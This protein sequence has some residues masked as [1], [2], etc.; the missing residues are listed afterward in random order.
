[1]KNRITAVYITD[2]N[3][4]MPTYISIF[5]MIK[6]K[7][8][9]DLLK[10]YLIGKGLSNQTK[11]RYNTLLCKDV[12]LE[13]IEV[14][15]DKYFLLSKTCLF[16]QTI[17]VSDAALFKM[18][19]PDLL[20]DEE[21]IL[22]IDGD[23]LIQGSLKGLFE[24]NIEKEYVAAV[25]DQ[26]D[27]KINGNSSFCHRIGLERKHYFNSGVMLLNLKKMRADNISRRLL[28][29]R[30][31]GINYFMDQD[32]LNA[33]LGERLVLLPCIYN[34]MSTISDVYDAEEIGEKFLGER[35]ESIEDCISKSI[36]LHLTDK[37]KP[38]IYNIPWYSDIF[39]KYYRESVYGNEKIIFKSPLKVLRD[40][41]QLLRERMNYMIQHTE[42]VF[43]YQL[44][45]KGS[46]V[47]LYGAG[48]MGQ[49]FYEQIQAT[50]YCNIVAWIDKRGNS[51]M[52]Q[53]GFPED[54]VKVTYDF[55]LIAI[56][57]QQIVS[58][59]KNLLKN[60]YHVQTEKI[61]SKF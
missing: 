59:V 44:L 40:E 49:S 11:S 12:S 38:W 37:K 29:Y 17:H 9:E 54:I 39:L 2:E 60:T 23:T 16:A 15:R 21:K 53:V 10:I 22:Y 27:E 36:I 26:F 42:F 30:S 52:D 24:T 4:A 8:E 41:N 50:N 19:L 35:T 55:I 28:E 1:M 45:P 6:N 43:P 34:F 46:K 32:C 31:Q 13:M 56:G 47:V 48:K 5:S 57:N 14:D 25:A 51:A 7:D 18:D 61:V 58:E 3:Y 20:A 33:V